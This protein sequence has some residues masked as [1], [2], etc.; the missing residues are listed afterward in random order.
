MKNAPCP[1]CRTSFLPITKESKK[2]TVTPTQITISSQPATVTCSGEIIPVTARTRA[3][4]ST[5]EPTIL[6]MAML[7]FPF[8]A[9]T[10]EVTSSGNEVP[11]ATTVS[12]MTLS[13]IPT[14]LAIA[15]APSTTRFPPSI[16]K[17]IPKK[18]YKAVFRF[19]RAGMS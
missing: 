19:G 8:R 11:I 12:P 1:L 6:P 10:T 5:L 3:I 14:Y 17:R 13:A 15:T 4:L 16:S 2:S 7:L 9:A 18:I